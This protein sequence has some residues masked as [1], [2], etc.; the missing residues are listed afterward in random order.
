MNIGPSIP[1][2]STINLGGRNTLQLLFYLPQADMTATTDQTTYQVFSGTLYIP[3]YI[4][5]LRRSGA[6]GTA[7]AGG[8]Y[9]AASKGGSAIVA[10]GQSYAALTGANKTVPAAIAIT[11]TVFSAIPI[12]SL[13][14]GNTGALRADV[15]IWG[16]C[17]DQ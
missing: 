4:D 14:T 10:A 17:V 9:T 8:I 3:K 15:Y 2:P 5:V 6:F 12:L 13:T 16:V 7:C 11:D 1:L